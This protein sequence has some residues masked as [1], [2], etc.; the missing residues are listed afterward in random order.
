MTRAE[1]LAMVKALSDEKLEQAKTLLLRRYA[2]VCEEI[3]ARRQ[4]NPTSRSK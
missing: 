2:D 3:A 4:S 1:E